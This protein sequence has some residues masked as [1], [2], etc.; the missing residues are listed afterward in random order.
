MKKTLLVTLMAVAFA[1]VASASTLSVP[2]FNDSGVIGTTFIA[3]HNNTA[4]AIDVGIFYFD[5]DGTEQTPS[6]N[7]FT[8]NGNTTLSFRP[9]AVDAASEGPGTAIPDKTGTK[10][11]GSLFIQWVGGPADIQGRLHTE[12]GNGSQF[13][14]LLPP[15]VSSAK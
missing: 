8:L 10:A 7:S 5:N 2:F 15:G 3:F 6:P 14:Y 11:A 13:S 1:G 9:A 4:T 12:S